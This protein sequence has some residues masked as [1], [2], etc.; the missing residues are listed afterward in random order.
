MVDKTIIKHRQETTK[1]QQ[2]DTADPK[3]AQELRAFTREWVER[4]SQH[5]AAALA[6]L[7]T[8][9][10]VQVAPEG[11]IYGRQAIENHYADIFQQWHPTDYIVNVEQVN[12][13]GNDAWDIGE[14]SCTLQTP[15]GA[16]P[17]KGYFAAICVREGDAWKMRLSSYNNARTPA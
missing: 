2:K 10:G 7:F 13:V 12:A 17:V 11:L 15:A 4:Y 16:L 1:M 9:D 6:A 8:D 3:I 14:W 5:D